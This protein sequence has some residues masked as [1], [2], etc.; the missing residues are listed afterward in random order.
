VNPLQQAFS[1]ERV[2]VAPD[3]HLGDTEQVRECRDADRAFGIEFL[4]DEVLPLGCEHVAPPFP[5]G[6]VRAQVAVG[7]L[8]ICGC[9]HCGTKRSKTNTF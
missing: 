8:T 4:E 3:G 2:N 5:V 6:S 9:S 1:I 7:P